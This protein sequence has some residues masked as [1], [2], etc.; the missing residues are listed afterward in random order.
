MFL[1]SFPCIILKSLYVFVSAANF[2][3]TYTARV[4]MLA[5]LSILDGC[6]LRELGASDKYFYYTASEPGMTMDIRLNLTFKS[7]VN[8]QALIMAA[9]EALRLYPEF[10]VQTVLNDGRLFYEENH[11]HVALLPSEPRYDFATSD[12]NGYLFCFQSDPS[13]KK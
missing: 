8:H 6:I 13:K 12:M 2:L 4:M 3:V 10:S 11:N 5:T 1:L 7:S 9:D